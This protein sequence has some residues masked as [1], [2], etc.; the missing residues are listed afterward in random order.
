MTEKLNKLQRS[1][2]AFNA[3]CKQQKEA[4][5]TIAGVSK[6]EERSMAAAIRK[7]DQ[8]KSS[9]KLQMAGVRVV[10]LQKK[11]QEMQQ[12]E[13]DERSGRDSALRRVQ[14]QS[15][16]T[17]NMIAAEAVGKSDCAKTNMNINYAIMQARE[18]LNDAVT[19]LLAKKDASSLLVERL[20][21]TEAEAKAAA[22]ASEG[23]PTTTNPY[24][25]ADVKVDTTRKKVQLGSIRLLGGDKDGEPSVTREVVLSRQA[26]RTLQSNVG[27]FQVS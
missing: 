26:V 14:R 19:K 18:Q 21:D 24:E 23:Q 8:L 5:S 11:R 20:N 13:E 17:E 6:D 7:I 16:V 27:L 3:Y 9:A 2:G 12:A 1:G 4:A 25:D 10:D 22:A 15:R